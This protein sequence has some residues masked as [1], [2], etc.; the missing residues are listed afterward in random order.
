MAQ[1]GPTRIEGLQPALAELAAQ[2]R[3]H[4]G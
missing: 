3:E 2:L 1:G 4:S